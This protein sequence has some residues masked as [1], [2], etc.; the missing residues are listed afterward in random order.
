MA[1]DAATVRMKRMTTLVIAAYG[2][3]TDCGGVATPD[4]QGFTA[5]TERL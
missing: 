3:T 1:P 2:T 5:M 4:P